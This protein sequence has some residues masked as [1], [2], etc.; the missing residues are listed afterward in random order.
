MGVRTGL[1]LGRGRLLRINIKVMR[2][3]YTVHIMRFYIQFVVE[4]LCILC[5]WWES[6]VDK[7]QDVYV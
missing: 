5:M 2:A 6:G 1:G 4:W 7:D 3:M